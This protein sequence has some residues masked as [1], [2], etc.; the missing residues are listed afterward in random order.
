MIDGMNK[1]NINAKYKNHIEIELVNYEKPKNL[2]ANISFD[3][4]KQK[5][6]V[7]NVLNYN[8]KKLQLF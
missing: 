3:L 6:L 1:L 2:V 8:E 5:L 7:F 4:E